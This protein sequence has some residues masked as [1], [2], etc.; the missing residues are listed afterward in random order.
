MTHVDP[1]TAVERNQTLSLIYAHRHA[2]DATLY[3]G[4]TASRNE[5]ADVE[6]KRDQRELFVKLSRLLNIF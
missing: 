5:N 4:V 1:V 3:F 6:F 2:L